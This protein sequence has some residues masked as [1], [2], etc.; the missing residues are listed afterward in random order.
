MAN[1]FVN[2][3]F[4]ADGDIGG[5]TATITG[6]I[7]GGS[8]SITN[9]CG[10]GQLNADNVRVDGNTVSITDVNGN[11]NIKANGTGGLILATPSDAQ[12]LVVDSTGIVRMPLQSSFVARLDT[13]ASNVTGDGTAYTI[14]GWTEVQDRNAD[15]NP[16]TGVFTCPSTGFYTF[17]AGLTI[18]GIASAHTQYRMYLSATGPVNYFLCQGNAYNYSDAGA[19]ITDGRSVTIYLSATNTVSLTVSAS[20]G[21][22]VVDIYGSSASYYSYFSGIYLG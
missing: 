13:T 7:G 19:T 20:N 4:N 3:D 10:C 8:A 6:A 21:T 22:K 17:T 14:T 2:D 1:G 11:M 16:T 15:F 5:A 9:A 12:G 18:N